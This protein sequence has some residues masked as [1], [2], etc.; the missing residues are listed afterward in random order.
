M[1]IKKFSSTLLFP[2]ICLLFLFLVIASHKMVL[3]HSWKANIGMK[4]LLSPCEQSEYGGS[5]FN[6]IKKFTYP[7]IWCQRICPSVCLWIFYNLVALNGLYC[8]L[9][10]VQDLSKSCMCE[11]LLSKEYY[12]T[13]ERILTIPCEYYFTILES[14]QQNKSN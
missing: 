5:K 10:H 12:N 1:E 2:Y 14:K 3:Q 6:W 11:H 9:L 8:Y 13:L 7:R 4:L